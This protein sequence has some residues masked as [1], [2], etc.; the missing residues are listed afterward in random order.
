MNGTQNN[1]HITIVNKGGQ[2]TPP[3]VKFVLIPH[4]IVHMTTTLKITTPDAIIAYPGA[5]CVDN[6]TTCLIV[7]T[8]VLQ[9][10]NQYDSLLKCVA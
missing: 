10:H 6:A 9:H 3:V 4:R 1:Y 8:Y 7:K 5:D 2:S